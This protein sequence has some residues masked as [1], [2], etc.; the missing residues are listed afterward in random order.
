MN[1]RTLC[2]FATGLGN[3][4]CMTPAVRALASM[5]HSGQVD[6][7]TDVGWIDSR[8]DGMVDLWK[9]LPFV[10]DVYSCDF[11]C[12]RGP[13]LGKDYA[14]WF[15]ADWATHGA[16]FEFFHNKFPYRAPVWDHSKTHETDYYFDIVRSFYGY[17]GEKPD[18]MV[19]PAPS[20]IFETRGRKLVCLCNGSFGEIAFAKKW[21][22]FPGLAD[23]LRGYYGDKIAIAKIGANRELE[24][25]Q[26]EFDFVG[27]LSFTETLRVLDQS[28]MLVTTDTGLM[29]AADAL[30]KPM[31]VL[32]GG[33]VLKK[34]EPIN[35]TAR[36]IHLGLSCQPCL[37]SGGYRTCEKY[38][39]MDGIT[40]SEV[41]FN[42]REM[43]N[44]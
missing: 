21:N 27:K 4:I 39:C 26:A 1:T 10:Q 33:S 8:K 2:H 16:A 14:V 34:N 3:F 17:A 12:E 36:V 23:A 6:L 24:D 15:Y 19:V 41:F 37:N 11:D 9:R 43:L 42:V 31:A 20:P 25:V 32:W 22:G 44:V 29:H 40:Q 18:Q 28:D 13:R 5:D 7:C 30:K 35:G 38:S